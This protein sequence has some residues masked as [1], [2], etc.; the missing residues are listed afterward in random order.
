MSS[1]HDRRSGFDPFLGE[2]ALV[3]DRRRLVLATPMR[4]DNYHV[5]LVAD[6]ADATRNVAFPAVQR[7]ELLRGRRPARY[8]GVAAE[9][10]DADAGRSVDV[11]RGSRCVVQTGPG[12]GDA[13]LV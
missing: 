1:S 6:G 5:G 7:A 8:D 13:P 11:R 10:R 3:G 12:V 2:L 9:D 4:V